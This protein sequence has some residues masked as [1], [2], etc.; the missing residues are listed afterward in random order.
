MFTER[1]VFHDAQLEVKTEG[2]H[3]PGYLKTHVV[4]WAIIENLVVRTDYVTILRRDQKY[5]QLEILNDVSQQEIEAINQFSQ[6]QI[7][8]FAPILVQS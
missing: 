8:Q 2:I 6:Q 7:H 4:P 5:V 3:I 1:K